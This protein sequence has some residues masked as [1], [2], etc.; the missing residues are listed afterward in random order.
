LSALT[1]VGCSR[2]S[3]ESEIKQQNDATLNYSMYSEVS[4][5]ILRNDGRSGGSGVIL[6]SGIM[7]S[8]I[9]T[10]KHI[11]NVIVK[12]GYVEKNSRS[13]RITQYKMYPFHDL[14]LIKVRNNLRV[15]TKIAEDTP[16]MYD[17][18]VVSGHPNLL[19]TVVANG[20]FSDSKIIQLIVGFKPCDQKTPDNMLGYCM[21]FGGIPIVE[22]YES[23]VISAQIKP[24]SS[25]SPVLTKNREIGG[26]V[27]A[28]QG[29]DF[30]YG[31]IVPHSYIAHFLDVERLISWKSISTLVDLSS[32]KEDE[33]IFGKMYVEDRCQTVQ[34]KKI[35]QFCRSLS[36]TPIGFR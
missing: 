32:T 2:V 36:T 33:E 12:G 35:F 3:A 16:R 20:H 21:F 24:G 19:P 8:T 23:V 6:N 14:C 22:E 26:L 1:I 29:R 25:G 18:A 28:G 27:F 30:S 31:Y 11:C 5:K 10:N 15:N 17:S 4:V 7:G 9:L 34:G 13:Y